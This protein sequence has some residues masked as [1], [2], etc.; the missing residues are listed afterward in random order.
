MT[1]VRRLKLTSSAHPTPARKKNFMTAVHCGT[2]SAVS[3]PM[4]WI[5]PLNR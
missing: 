5:R 3:S 4:A 2:G 1:P